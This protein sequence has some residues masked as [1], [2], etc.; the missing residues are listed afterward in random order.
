MGSTLYSRTSIART[1]MACLSWLIR[2]C[3]WVRGGSNRYP[4]SMIWAEIWKTDFWKFSVFGGKIFFI[5]KLVCFRNGRKVSSCGQ[6]RLIRLRECAGFICVYVG[7]T[8]QKVRF[9]HVAAQTI[10][11]FCI[12]VPQ[13]PINGLERLTATSLKRP[14][15]SSLSFIVWN[16]LPASFVMHFLNGK[17][18]VPG[19]FPP[20]IPEKNIF[21]TIYSSRRGVVLLS[22]WKYWFFFSKIFFFFLCWN[23]IIVILFLHENICCGFL[24]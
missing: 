14:R 24:L 3:F 9:S 6:R 1:P 7:H 17:F 4:Q 11:K 19:I 21:K 5:F 13:V 15:S 18:S 8:C 22:K 20:G 12:P 10:L 16:R 2:T 23:V